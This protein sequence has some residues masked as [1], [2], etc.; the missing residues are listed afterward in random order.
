MWT[1]FT[2]TQFHLLHALPIIVLTLLPEWGIFSKLFLSLSSSSLKIYVWIF[3]PSALVDRFNTVMVRL[4][5][6]M[7]FENL[8]ISTPSGIKYFLST[9]S[10][11]IAAGLPFASVMISSLVHLIILAYPH[12]P[13]QSWLFHSR[14]SLNINWIHTDS[15]SLVWSINTPVEVSAPSCRFV[16][17]Q[18]DSLLPPC[19]NASTQMFIDGRIIYLYIILTLFIIP[20][21]RTLYELR[22]FFT[23]MAKFTSWVSLALILNFVGAI[24]F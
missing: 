8:L 3:L 20:L 19:R 13:S 22:S 14:G 12:S 23:P 24:P 4:D 2:T 16:F 21:T 5:R 18:Y 9:M 7:A 15:Q 6:L 11:C 10:K 1:F 17:G